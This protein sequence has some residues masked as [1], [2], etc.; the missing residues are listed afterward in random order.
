MSRGVRLRL[1]EGL[2]GQ[3]VLPSR[4]KTR[5]DCTHPRPCPF[6]SCRYHLAINVA[7]TGRIIVNQDLDNLDLYPY[8]CALDVTD[9][10]YLT[11]DE[12][13]SLIG[14]TRERIRQMQEVAI[15]KLK[16]EMLKIDGLRG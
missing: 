7:Y 12:V 3:D 1:I 4:P 13:G 9:K 2:V 11:L 5:G 8:N 14:L 16:R 6:V 15:R 10:G